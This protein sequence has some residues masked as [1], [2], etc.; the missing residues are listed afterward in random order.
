LLTR[1]A[2]FLFTQIRLKGQLLFT[3]AGAKGKSLVNKGLTQTIANATGYASLLPPMS[4]NSAMQVL[5]H[6]LSF[7]YS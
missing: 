4:G 1:D 5:V 6:G 7:I 2:C 3:N